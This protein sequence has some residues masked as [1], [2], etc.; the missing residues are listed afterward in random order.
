MK[1]PDEAEFLRMQK[2]P[3]DKSIAFFIV[4]K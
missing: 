2:V 4:T 1:K 3:G